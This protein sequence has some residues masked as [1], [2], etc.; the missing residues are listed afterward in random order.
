[1]VVA[2]ALMPIPSIAEKSL[3]CDHPRNETTWILPSNFPII[4]AHDNAHSSEFHETLIILHKCCQCSVRLNTMDCEDWSEASCISSLIIVWPSHTVRHAFV[5]LNYLQKRAKLTVSYSSLY[6]DKH[7]R[8]DSDWAI[9]STFSWAL[10]GTIAPRNRSHTLRPTRSS[11]H[12]SKIPELAPLPL[13]PR[14]FKLSWW[15][16]GD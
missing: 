14:V 9:C 6:A 1:M 2:R 10:K 7:V 16:L 5:K 3:D 11:A 12:S 13:L 8:E 15:T 4:S